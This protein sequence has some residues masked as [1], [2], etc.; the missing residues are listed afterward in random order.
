MKNINYENR[1]KEILPI[2]DKLINASRA[3][4]VSTVENATKAC[5]NI[6]SIIEEWRAFI[7]EV[8]KGEK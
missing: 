2:M 7:T 4:T 6:E 5:S 3:L 1:F 8:A